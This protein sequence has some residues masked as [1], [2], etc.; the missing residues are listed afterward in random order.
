MSTDTHIVR[1]QRRGPEVMETREKENQVQ[2]GG[3]KASPPVS[4]SSE[5][6]LC[7]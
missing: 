7:S 4:S 2:I 3:E 1:K 6:N 5:G